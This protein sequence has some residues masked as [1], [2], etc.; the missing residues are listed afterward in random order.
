MS[1]TLQKIGVLL[2]TYAIKLEALLM[3]KMP[4]HVIYLVNVKVLSN[5]Y[6]FS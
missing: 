2:W 3:G 1:I 4:S 6:L 5:L